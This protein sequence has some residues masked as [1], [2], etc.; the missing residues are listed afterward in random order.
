MDYERICGMKTRDGDDLFII[1]GVSVTTTLPHGKPADVRREMDW[2][3]EKGPKLG[4]MLGCSSSIAPGVP[5]ENMKTLIEG[6]RHYRE[7]H[8]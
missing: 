1:A 2:L 6:F 7:R 4:L 5:L 8:A 3:V